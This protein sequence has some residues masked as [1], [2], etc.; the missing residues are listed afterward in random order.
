M[1]QATE[2]HDKAA[3]GVRENGAEAQRQ[4]SEQAQRA[5]RLVSTALPVC[6]LS[7]RLQRDRSRA[8]TRCLLPYLLLLIFCD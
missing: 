3:R 1:A 2:V 7:A 4:I 6:P 8:I 5:W